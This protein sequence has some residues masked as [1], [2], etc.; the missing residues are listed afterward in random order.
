MIQIDMI[1]L[2]PTN[3]QSFTCNFPT[4]VKLFISYIASKGY[5]LNSHLRHQLVESETRSSHFKTALYKSVFKR[6]LLVH[7][8]IFSH[9]PSSL[10]TFVNFQTLCR[11]VGLLEPFN[12]VIQVLN[13]FQLTFPSPVRFF[14]PSILSH[15]M[16]FLFRRSYGFLT[17]RSQ[18][19][20]QH[21]SFLY[22]IFHH[23]TSP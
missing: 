10:T 20:Y 4:G 22:L 14:L 15:S 18:G 7:L 6:W 21:C 5:C 17:N 19:T 1:T 12:D 3:I 9:T 13:C 23:P 11:L 16:S 2:R 8:K